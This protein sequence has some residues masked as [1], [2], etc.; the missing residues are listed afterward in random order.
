MRQYHSKQRTSRL[1]QG[2]CV[3]CAKPATR[4]QRCEACAVRNVRHAVESKRRKRAA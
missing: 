1:E 3:D 2:L 4:G